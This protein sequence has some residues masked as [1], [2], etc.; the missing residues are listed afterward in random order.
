MP[1][2]REGSVQ[3][4]FVFM[5]VLRNT[6]DSVWV[7]LHEISSLLRKTVHVGGAV[8][9]ATRILRRTDPP[10]KDPKLCLKIIRDVNSL[11]YEQAKGPRSQYR[12]KIY[13]KLN[14]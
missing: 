5:A 7:Q 12:E 1:A 4:N 10:I 13:M 8:E 6:N 9:I 2:A 11:G 3:S 14:A